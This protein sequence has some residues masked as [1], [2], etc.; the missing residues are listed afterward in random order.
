M[1]RFAA[2][3]HRGLEDAG[4]EVR[5]VKPPVRLGCLVPGGEASFAKWVG[6]MDR[7]ILYPPQLRRHA[8]WADVIHICDQVNAV[9]IPHLKARPHVL[10]CHD[11]FAIQA[12]QGEIAI[13]PTGWTGRIFQRWILRNLSKSRQVACVSRQTR[14]ELQRITGLPEERTHFV[15]NALNY[16]YKPM[17]AKEART[18]MQSLQLDPDRPFIMHIGGNDWYKNRKGVVGIFSELKQYDGFAGHHLVMAGKPWPDELRSMINGSGLADCIHERI[19]LD[20]EDLRALYTRAAALLFPSLQ[21]GFGWPIVEAQA[22]GCPVVTTERAPM[23]DVGGRGAIYIDPEDGRG[24]AKKMLEALR[25]RQGWVTAGFENTNRFS[26][27]KM[28]G[29]YVA[30]YRKAM[31]DQSI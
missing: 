3:L 27:D 18:R 8:R 24:A 28:I 22:C 12:A 10:T 30:L 29:G 13:S 19:A 9:Y 21:E 6:Y 25:N 31:E 5:L 11:L 4:H 14:S 15:H 7:F 1:Q 2:L 16:P 23:T 20:N 26:R 17:G